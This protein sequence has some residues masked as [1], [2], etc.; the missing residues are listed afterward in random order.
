MK[1]RLWGLVLLVMIGAVVAV[2]SARSARSTLLTTTVCEGV[3]A[4][5]AAAAD[6]LDL[7]AIEPEDLPQALECLCVAASLRQDMATC[8]RAVVATGT[9][10]ASA[11]VTW[12]LS[13]WFERQD[14]LPRAIEAAWLATRS[15]LEGLAPDERGML[16]VA[17]RAARIGLAGLAEDVVVARCAPP[18][19]VALGVACAEMMIDLGLPENVLTLVDTAPG[20]P[21]LT[22]R[23]AVRARA[24]AEL[25]RPALL[26]ELAAAWRSVGV[27]DA[28]VEARVGYALY[29]SMQDPR[30]NFERAWRGREALTP[31]LQLLVARRLL[32][33]ALVLGDETRAQALL[34]EARAVGLAGL[35]MPVS[36]TAV[37]PMA[38]GPVTLAA[39]ISGTLTLVDGT[40]PTSTPPRREVLA[41]GQEV[42]VTPVPGPHPLRF[43]FVDDVGRS[44]MGNVPL[45]P[46]GVRVVLEPTS[47]PRPE[48][49]PMPGTGAGDGI[50]HIAV[51]IADSAD[52]RLVRLAEAAGLM[53]H[54]HGVLD[55]AVRGVLIS[56]PPSTGAAMRKLRTPGRKAENTAGLLTAF[57]TQLQAG[58]QLPENPFAGLQLLARDDSVSLVDKLA[59]FRWS[60]VDMTF[61][62]G[63]AKGRAITVVGPGRDRVWKVKTGPLR[64][65]QPGDGI[66]VL[67]HAP[68]VSRELDRAAAQF[69]VVETL[70][71]EAEPRVLLYR[72]DPTDIIAHNFYPSLERE[73]SIAMPD[74]LLDAY[75]YLDVRLGRLLRQLDDDDVL[76]LVSDH[77]T[78]NASVHA[79][80]ALFVVYGAHT[81]AEDVGALPFEVLP[82]LVASLA[83]L[84]GH[85]L[86]MAWAEPSH[87][88]C[89]AAGQR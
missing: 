79:R 46:E 38:P 68:L 30:P 61:G 88:A 21:L 42:V 70:L 13:I 1:A 27:S 44:V 16:A 20:A 23:F 75:A 64:G 18:Q 52:W 10:P 76:I 55:R 63:E 67:A 26:D 45:R 47:P 83:C 12:E 85:R 5:D 15:G 72:Y 62:H 77:G 43:V 14:D 69:D 74:P 8:A 31:E 81:V 28:E 32:Q 34:A 58:L 37:I 7:Q 51:V 24:L 22:E 66:D 6:G 82:E 3:A 35:A 41:A 19:P 29:A 78:E 11:Q 54:L 84:P 59:H 17:R 9:F 56:D 40:I 87:A 4:G 65:V 2:R 49:A 86:P 80:E 50:P 89:A 25:R 73:G 48:T 53:P 71:G 39:P 60:A 57:G 33:S 36:R